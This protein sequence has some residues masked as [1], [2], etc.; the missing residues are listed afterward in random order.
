MLAACLAQW[1]DLRP[2]QLIAV[3][4]HVCRRG[5]HCHS[6]KNI[7]FH[8]SLGPRSAQFVKETLQNTSSAAGDRIAFATLGRPTSR[9]KANSEAQAQSSS[10]GT[11][12]PSYMGP[13]VTRA[14][15][16]WGATPPRRKNSHRTGV[17]HTHRARGVE[18]CASPSSEDEV[19]ALLH[20]S[21]IDVSP[22]PSLIPLAGWL[23]SCCTGFGD[24][25]IFGR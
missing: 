9:T 15:R 17:I 10:S 20:P 21:H 16:S 7:G 25:V 24:V 2:V 5:R 13:S 22:P 12:E 18:R 3:E 4:R 19:E 6:H 8:Q 11:L 1:L 14:S 23:G